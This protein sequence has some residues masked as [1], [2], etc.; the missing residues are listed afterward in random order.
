MILGSLG[1]NTIPPVPE[2]VAFQVPPDTSQVEQVPDG[3]TVVTQDLVD[4]SH[5]VGL[6]VQVWTINECEQMLELI[7]LGV[8]ALM[9][10]R[11][12]LL[13]QLLAQPRGERSCD[14]L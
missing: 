14:G 1:D 4:D 2:H 9:T 7:D 5:A 13:A 8:D 6:A 12:V 11:P 3:I 10:D